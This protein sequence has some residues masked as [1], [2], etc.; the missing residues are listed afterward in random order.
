MHTEFIRQPE[1]RPEHMQDD[2]IIINF[3]EIW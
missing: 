2:N 1:G 3:G